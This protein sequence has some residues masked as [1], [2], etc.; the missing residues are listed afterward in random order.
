MG[1]LC[2]AVQLDSGTAVEL[3]LGLQNPPSK[4]LSLNAAWRSGCGPGS[5]EEPEVMLG[6]SQERGLVA[7]WGKGLAWEKLAMGSRDKGRP[8]WLQE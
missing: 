5:G 1:H 8:S 6:L 4:P 7:S 2:K 3:G